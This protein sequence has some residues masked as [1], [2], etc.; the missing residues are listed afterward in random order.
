MSGSRVTD[1]P[2]P[3]SLPPVSRP[4]EGLPREYRALRPLLS[5]ATL[6]L[7]GAVL[8]WAGAV[9]IPVAI[10]TLLAFLLTPLVTT[11]QRRGLRRGIAV[12]LVVVM[13]FLL[14]G[15]IGWVLTAQIS[16]LATELPLYRGNIKQKIADLRAATHGTMLHGLQRIVDDVVG[17]IRKEERPIP[18]KDKP[19][20]VIIQADP[21]QAL[22][23]QLPNAVE[24]L[25]TFGLVVA[26][27]VFML[28]RR[29][30]LRNRLIR[31][32]GYGR[33]PLATKAMD[34]AA[35]RIGHYLVAQ[36]LINGSFGV[37]MATGLYFIGLPYATLFGFLAGMLRFVPYL[38]A[39]AAALL[40][41][42]LALAVFQGWLQPILVLALFAVVEPLVFLVV[43][44]VIYGT[45]AGVSDVALLVAVGFWTWLWGPVGLI[46]ATPLT[47]CLV[48]LGKYVPAMEFLVVL[49]GDEPVMEPHL[50]YY[51]RLLAMD[52]DEAEE[53][54]REYVK[55]HSPDAVYDGVLIP[56]LKCT[57]RDR[58]QGGLTE[59]DEAFVLTATREIVEGLDAG[60]P[61]E[62]VGVGLDDSDDGATVR[63]LGCPA[64][65]EADEVALLMLSQ[66]LPETCCRF[67]LA[68]SA[69]LSSEMVAL[70]RATRPALVCIATLPPGGLSHARYL[71]K[72]LRAALPEAT[73]LVGR[74]GRNGDPEEIRG[75]LLAA[76]ADQV[77]ATLAE[78]RVQILQLVPTLGRRAGE[79]AGQERSRYTA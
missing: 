36:S 35:E 42:T 38:G 30:E 43:E 26:L 5:F 66:L 10:A 62:A 74:W 16:N 60:R 4:R 32:V 68:S 73:I 50:L 25:V 34:E 28:I 61:V 67:E 48:V 77:A 18:A 24:A 59:A 52:Q 55:A 3:P 37:A 31:L 8:Y 63:V 12:V 58:L 40:P 51:Q 57:K 6:V 7:V 44:P 9:L 29:I 47:V 79:P 19:I 49:L 41:L 13:A 20:P 46:L 15:G 45:R 14:L 78:T 64:R 72:R 53:I 27:V 70:A 1:E 33:L 23:R 22:L 17:E 21:Q 39:W 65:D 71:V 76:G 54:M 69:M 56:A 11:L 2:V 75:P